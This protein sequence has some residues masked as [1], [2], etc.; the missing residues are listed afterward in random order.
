MRTQVW[1]RGK[2][3]MGAGARACVD[4]CVRVDM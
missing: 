3:G 4:A 1:E 2:G